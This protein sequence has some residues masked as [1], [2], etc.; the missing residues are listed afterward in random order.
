MVQLILI[1]EYFPLNIDPDVC[2]YDVYRLVE[3][4]K[5]HVCWGW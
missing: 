4:T 1:R 3:K 2:Q 5:I